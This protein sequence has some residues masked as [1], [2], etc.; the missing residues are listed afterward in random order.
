MQTLSEAE[1]TGAMTGGTKGTG[2]SG[3]RMDRALFGEPD[4]DF[5]RLPQ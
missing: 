3:L 5:D 2:F 4:N 1:H